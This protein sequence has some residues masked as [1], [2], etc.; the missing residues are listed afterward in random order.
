[1][2]DSLKIKNNSTKNNRVNNSI[3]KEEL[4]CSNN[5]DHS[6]RWINERLKT[7]KN[8]DDRQILL[9]IEIERAEKYI[10]LEHKSELRFGQP[11][12]VDIRINYAREFENFLI[13]KYA[14]LF[15]S[16]ERKMGYEMPENSNYGYKK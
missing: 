7:L 9:S 4:E 16:E 6:I 12:I 1:M 13:K 11:Y 15:P 10:L 14:E 8:A 2:E 5:N 3:E